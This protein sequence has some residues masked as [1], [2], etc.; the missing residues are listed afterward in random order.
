MIREF[1]GKLG[2]NLMM[3]PTV[4]LMFIVPAIVKMAG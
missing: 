3:I 2:C 1:L 4:T